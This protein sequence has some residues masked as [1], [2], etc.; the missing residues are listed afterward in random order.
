MYIDEEKMISK[1][2]LSLFKK[3]KTR[4]QVWIETV[5]YTLIG[6][7]IIGILI[8][9]STPKINSYRDKLLIGQTIESLNNIESKVQEVR[10]AAGNRRVIDL[11][12]TKGN[13]VIDGINN[14]VLWKLNSNY[15][16][17]EEDAEINVGNLKLK[18]KKGNP[19]EIEIWRDYKNI[20]NITYS[21]KDELKQFD[22]APSPYS[23]SIENL[24]TTSPNSLINVDFR[25]I[26]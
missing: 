4:A 17:S 9:V 3:R 21:K 22:T 18:T 14:K 16:Y 6:I 2:N 26:S 23:L 13:L 12:I 24:G 19:W 25:S 7:S 10:V 5:V 1:I 15:Q 8:A 11:K 20:L